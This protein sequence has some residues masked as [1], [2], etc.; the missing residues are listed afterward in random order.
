M[1]LVICKRVVI[2]LVGGDAKI[3]M[4]IDDLRIRGWS[5]IFV[6]SWWRTTGSGECFQERVAFTGLGLM[7]GGL[8]GVVGINYCGMSSCLDESL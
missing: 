4:A 3:S 1:S 8:G 6:A 7:G 5:G 2:L